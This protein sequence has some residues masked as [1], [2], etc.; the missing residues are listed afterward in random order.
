MSADASFKKETLVSNLE[1][2]QEPC[3]CCIKRRLCVLCAH[4][5]YELH[6]DGLLCSADTTSQVADHHPPRVAHHR[7]VLHY[8][9]ILTKAMRRTASHAILTA[10]NKILYGLLNSGHCLDALTAQSLT[11]Q[12]DTPAIGVPTSI[13]HKNQKTKKRTSVDLNPRANYTD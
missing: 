3:V 7:L 9:S 8:V 10:G 6:R 4:V 13:H 5:W 11:V 1:R 2:L 12:S